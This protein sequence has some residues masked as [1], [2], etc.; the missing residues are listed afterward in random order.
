MA[1]VERV[2]ME[3]IMVTDM[4]LREAS[5]CQIRLSLSLSPSLSLTGLSLNTLSLWG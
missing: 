1:R 5:L 2:D 3:A 4:D